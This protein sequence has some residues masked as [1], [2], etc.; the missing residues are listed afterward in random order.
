MLKDFYD[1]DSKPI[2]NL[3]AFYGPKKNYVDKCIVIFSIDIYNNLLKLYPCEKI[4]EIGACNGSIPVYSFIYNKEKVVFYLSPITS[5]VAGGAIIEVNHLT[6]ANKFVMFGSCGTLDPDKTNGK[7]IVPTF[8]YRG[9]GM[10]FY[11]AK[12]SDYIKI[13]NAD[14]LAKIFDDLKIP[15]VLGRVWTTECML[16]ETVNLVNKRKEE[17]CIGVE[18]ELAGV[19]A[20]CDFY[21]FELYD[22]LAGGDVVSSDNYDITNLSDAN[23]NVDKLKIALRILERI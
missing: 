20:V 9:E 11:F 4:A 10:S 15:Y 8:A 7:I 18:M 19:Q 6:G 2:V 5:A 21:G 14:N 23:H 12:P 13:K 22:F 1:I 16:R 17:G 3:E